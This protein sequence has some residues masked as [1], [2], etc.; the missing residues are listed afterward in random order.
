MN[1][2]WGRVAVATV[3]FTSAGLVA[4]S[5][6]LFPQCFEAEKKA[7]DLAIGK[8]ME[9]NK[10]STEIFQDPDTRLWC[11]DRKRHYEVD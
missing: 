7:L 4:Q 6:F 11:W 5:L 3:F 8:M 2:R 9:D 1:I 10:R